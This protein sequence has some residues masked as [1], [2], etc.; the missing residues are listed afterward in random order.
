MHTFMRRASSRYS[1]IPGLCWV[2][3]TSEV[4]GSVCFSFHLLTTLAPAY[5]V[6]LIASAWSCEM[7]YL[8]KCT[9]AF[10]HECAM[11]N[12]LRTVGSG[13]LHHGIRCR[14]SS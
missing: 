7:N 14:S 13:E 3:M 10:A 4:T 11:V 2:G 5:Q 12:P 8:T 6:K 1:F 9:V